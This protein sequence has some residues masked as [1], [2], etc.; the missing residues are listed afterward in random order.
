[1]GIDMAGVRTHRSL[2]DA[3]YHFVRPKRQVRTDR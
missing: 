2:R 1:M 3:L